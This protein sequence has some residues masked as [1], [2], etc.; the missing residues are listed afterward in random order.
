METPD[1]KIIIDA[2]IECTK[3][4]GTGLYIGMA[5]RGGAA[6][7]CYHCNGTGKEHIHKEYVK[8][9]ERKDNPNVSRVYKTGGTFCISAKDCVTNEGKVIKFSQ[10]GCTYE[11]WKNGVEPKPIR[12][13]LCPILHYLQGTEIGNKILEQICGGFVKMAGV[14]FPACAKDNR[15]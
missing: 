1:N 4:N 10:Y 3:C 15:E 14:Y 12:D 11:E 8:F 7:I 13:L 5:E 2:D 6:V 9:T